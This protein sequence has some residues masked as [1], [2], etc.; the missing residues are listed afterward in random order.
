MAYNLHGTNETMS[1]LCFEE[2]SSVD[3][4]ETLW[5]IRRFILG[6]KPVKT[7]Q[8]SDLQNKQ[9]LLDMKHVGEERFQL[10]VTQS[11]LESAYWGRFCESKCGTFRCIF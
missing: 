4:V 8:R 5:N 1:N 11:P 7:V 3:V 6:I 9:T 10:G 2:A